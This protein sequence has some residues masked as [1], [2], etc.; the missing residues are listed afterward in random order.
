MGLPDCDGSGFLVLSDGA[1]LGLQYVV[2]VCELDADGGVGGALEGVALAV[3]ED[4]GESEVVACLEG[5]VSD[6]GTAE[7]EACACG[8]AVGE[9]LLA[10]EVVLLGAAFAQG[11]GGGVPRACLGLALADAESYLGAKDDV[12]HEAF[13]LSSPAEAGEEGDADI[14]LGAPVGVV[15][16]L[17]VFLPAELG[18]VDL[19]LQGAYGGEVFLA[20][21]AQGDAHLESHV[22]VLR[23]AG[24]E[25]HAVH[26]DA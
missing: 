2:E 17:Y 8:D 16:G 4:V 20:R 14:A 1:G 9:F 3:V 11:Q 15:A 24:L 10:L 21:V 18:V 7:L 6:F 5:E 12:A 13:A 19:G 25:A 23:H 22:H 26:G